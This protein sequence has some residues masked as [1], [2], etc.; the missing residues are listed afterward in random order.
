MHWS[1]TNVKRM[2]QTSER[3]NAVVLGG[4]F[5]H[6]ERGTGGNF[7]LCY[8]GSRLVT[9]HPDNTFT[10]ST[11]GYKTKTTKSRLNEYGPAKVFAKKGIWFIETPDGPV[12]F[13]DGIRVDA[14]GEPVDDEDYSELNPPDSSGMEATTDNQIG[15]MFL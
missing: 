5:T 6:F 2:M 13:F 9:Y 8:Q 3:E 4:A 7:C 10:L 12:E 14:F 1:H 15:K 11:N